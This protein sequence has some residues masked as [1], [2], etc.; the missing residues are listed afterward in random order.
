MQDVTTLLYTLMGFMIV[1]SLVAI[2]TR[3]LLSSV[4]C[5]G[6]VGFALSVINLL[7]GAPDLALTLVVVEVLTL[8]VLI[9]SL[10]TRRDTYHATSRDTLAI[11]FVVAGLCFVL[12]VAYLSLGGLAAFGKPIMLMSGPYV[13]KGVSSNGAVNYVTSILLDFRAYDTLG[14]ATVIFA[15]VIGAYAVL[16]R[17]GRKR[18]E[19]GNESDR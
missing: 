6:A 10:G 3:D 1:G 4:I 9:R 7:L 18:E 8:V 12:T 15:A 2:E 17:V 5:V 11:A 13:Q 14:E 16:R 19:R